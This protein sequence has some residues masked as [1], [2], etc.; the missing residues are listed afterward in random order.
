M[1]NQINSES[2]EV[3]EVQVEGLAGPKGDK[4]DPFTY[5]DFTEEQ[6][7]PLKTL[8]DEAQIAANSAKDSLNLTQS[9]ANEVLTYKDDIEA[10]NNLKENI[11]ELSEIKEQVVELSLVKD[12][13]S[14]VSE[15]K[16]QITLIGSN[17]ESVKALYNTLNMSVDSTTLPSGTKA[18]VLKEA[19]D[20]GY[21]LTFGIPKGEKGDK[22]DSAPSDVIRYVDQTLTDD[23]KAKARENISAVALGDSG[24]VSVDGNFKANN[25][26]IT[27]GRIDIKSGIGSV[28]ATSSNGVADLNLISSLGGKSGI[29]KVKSTG[30]MLLNNNIVP[31]S[32]NSINADETGNIDLSSKFISVDTPTFSEEV[33]FEK[34]IR[35]KKGFELDANT[36]SYDFGYNWDNGA[37]PGFAMRGAKF[38]GAG[39]G[40]GC[41]V[42]WARKDTSGQIKLIGSPN[43]TL[44]WNG[45]NVEGVLSQVKGSTS[46]STW[47]QHYTSGFLQQGGYIAID[48][49]NNLSKI[50]FSVPYKHTPSVQITFIDSSK[51][52]P[53]WLKDIDS[54]GF[55][56]ATTSTTVTGLVWSALGYA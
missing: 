39:D 45:S 4:G 28:S 13:I 51:S 20:Q 11:Q 10:V 47:K 18:F 55:T 44:S 26:S 17:E 42:F 23:Q 2:F 24:S 32:V 19:N 36:M 22:G 15:I 9:L 35:L 7:A 14:D 31:L 46:T 41:F 56:P 6:L 3:V 5:E 21:K 38:S 27:N 52:A 48:D 1:S 34:G 54:L 37:G 8:K 30:S 12:A 25:V 43:G 29:L 50:V 40:P 33:T 53:S 16:D 49:I